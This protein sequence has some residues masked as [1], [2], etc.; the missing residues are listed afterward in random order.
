MFTL[1]SISIGWAMMVSEAVLIV[2]A[3]PR[4]VEPQELRNLTSRI[5]R[6]EVSVSL[7]EDSGVYEHI[8]YHF[9]IG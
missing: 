3:G 5:E 9:L 7:V 6:I 4:G 8:L 1:P 2:S